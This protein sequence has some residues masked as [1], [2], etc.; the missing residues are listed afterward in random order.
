MRVD[1]EILYYYTKGIVMAI[2]LC[3]ECKNEISTKAKLCPTCGAPVKKKNSLLTWLV[4]IVLVVSFFN[5][6]TSPPINKTKQPTK[7][8][9]E[10]TTPPTAK[11][12]LTEEHKKN[13]EG[14]TSAKRTAPSQDSITSIN[15][16]EAFNISSCV[17]ASYYISHDFSKT[18][19]G[20]T[21][22]WR[23]AM[24]KNLGVGRF[25]PNGKFVTANYN[26]YE[27]T[28]GKKAAA[29]FIWDTYNCANYL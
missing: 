12:S 14:V 15:D 11:H 25:A 27:S 7:Q 4:F 13:E 24:F 2:I 16:P 19:W 29:D 18:K 6:L 3:R 20:R 17:K 5:I 28:Q 1:R 10:A 8:D 21:F 26:L 23:A 22:D 9:V